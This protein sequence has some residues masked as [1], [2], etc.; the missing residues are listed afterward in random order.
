MSRVV[1][2]LTEHITN[3][4]ESVED[5]LYIKQTENTDS[6]ENNVVKNMLDNRQDDNMDEEIDNVMDKVEKNVNEVEKNVVGQGN[7]DF[8]ALQNL[9]VD[10]ALAFFSS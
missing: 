3:A 4:E 1:G 10:E 7:I 9:S 8:Q 6:D 2:P 5:P